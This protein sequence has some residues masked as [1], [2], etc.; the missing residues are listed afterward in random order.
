MDSDRKGCRR[1][2]GWWLLGLL[3]LP[4]LTG[5]VAQGQERRMERVLFAIPSRSLTFFPAM[6]AFKK[7]FYRQEGL[8]VKFVQMKCTLHTPG[9]IS[10]EVDYS[11]CT[12]SI[13]QAAVG[14]AAVKK[15]VNITGKPL[16]ALLVNPRYNSLQEMKGGRI[17]IDSF[18][19]LPEWEVKAV[20]EHYRLPSNW[21]T[22]LQVG[23]DNSR[24]VALKA[25][26]VDGSVLSMPY[27]LQAE[28]MGF[29]TLVRMSELLDLPFAGLGT[30]VAK[31]EHRPDQIKK[32]V[33]ATLRGIAYAKGNRQ[34]AVDLLAEWVEMEREMAARAYDRAVPAWTDTG[35]PAERGMRFTVDTARQRLG[36]KKE[37]P[38]T[39][40]ADWSFA[41]MAYRELGR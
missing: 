38:L 32:V 35:I 16:H 7:G 13:M 1:W 4:L 14:G 24:V 33:R 26:S 39:Q 21:F 36:I 15:I 34:E 17:A 2:G 29:R 5:G 22:L 28:K 37:I 10:G 41:E 8:E 31:I 40:V 3:L 20:L 11:T 30:S 23:G 12:T 19:S 6:V 18:G 27:D 9:L 25:G